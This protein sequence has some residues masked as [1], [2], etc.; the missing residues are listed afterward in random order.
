MVPDFHQESKWQTLAA[1]LLSLFFLFQRNSVLF[2]GEWLVV[3]DQAQHV[4][5]VRGRTVKALKQTIK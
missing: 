4:T 3:G 5:T 1:C 2:F